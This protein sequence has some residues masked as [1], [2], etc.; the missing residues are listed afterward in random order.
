MVIWHDLRQL[1]TNVQLSDAHCVNNNRSSLP[2][3]AAV[4]VLVGD[5]PLVLEPLDVAVPDRLLESLVH[6]LVVVLRVVLPDA[7]RHPLHVG[8]L[9]LVLDLVDSVQK[10][11]DPGGGSFLLTR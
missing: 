10:P 11:R 6:R 2:S 9:L 1:C 3:L 5:V 4:G 8:P 7:G